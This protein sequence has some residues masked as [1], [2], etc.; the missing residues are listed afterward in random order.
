MTKAVKKGDEYVINGGKMWTTNGAQADWMCLLANTSDGPPHRNKSLICLP[1]NLPGRS[2]SV[3]TMNFLAQ[4]MQHSSPICLQVVLLLALTVV[5]D[6]AIAGC[7]ASVHS[8]S[9]CKKSGQRNYVVSAMI[10]VE[11]TYAFY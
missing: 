6:M 9:N 7:L 5:S 4:Y 2:Q 11:Q 3:I 1:M 8:K 10:N